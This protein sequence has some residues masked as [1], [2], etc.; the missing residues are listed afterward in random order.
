MAE[1]Y[2]GEIKLFSFKKI[3]TGWLSCDGILLKIAQYQALYSVLGI[4]YGGDA[5]TTFGLPDLRGRVMVAAYT[6]TTSGA[7]HQGQT[8][9]SELATLSSLQIPQ[10]NHDFI[11]SSTTGTVTGV[12]NGTYAVVENPTPQLLYAPTT[13]SWVTLENSTLQYSGGGQA[14]SNIQPYLTLNYCIAVQGIYPPR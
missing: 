11:V 10:H 3:P 5:K 2:I 14:H 8:G 9:G 1:P 13:G 6:Q 12:V 4:T 7:F